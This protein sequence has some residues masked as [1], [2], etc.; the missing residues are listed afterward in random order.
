MTELESPQGLPHSTRGKRCDRRRRRRRDAPSPSSSQP[1]SS[2]SSSLSF[3][4]LKPRHAGNVL[5]IILTYM[6]TASLL[7]TPTAATYSVVVNDGSEEC[8]TTRTPREGGR[9]IVSG[10]YDLLDDGV[11]SRPLSVALYNS[12]MKPVY[13]SRFGRSEDTFSVVSTAGER[14]LLCLKNGFGLHQGRLDRS[15]GEMD[16]DDETGGNGGRD[17]LDRAV[18]WALRVRSADAHARWTREKDGGDAEDN[19]TNTM[20]KS[21]SEKKAESL[22]ELGGDLIDALEN[23]ADHQGYL[24]EREAAHRALAEET[25]SAVFFWTV[26]EALVL[27]TVA[28]GQIFYLR[29]FIEK[30]RY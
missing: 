19:D 25:F 28:G 17:G 9:Y 23:M 3:G 10:N 2:S 16:D 29:R 20:E 27:L 15:D 22:L 18:G 11:S 7:L 5:L 4:R 14:F 30:R 1:S 13:Q 21:E 26:I 24:R 12:K 6:T 8:F